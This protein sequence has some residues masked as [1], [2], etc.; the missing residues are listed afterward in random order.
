MVIRSKQYSI[1]KIAYLATKKEVIENDYVL[2]IS[3]YVDTFDEIIIPDLADVTKKI[4]DIERELKVVGK[5]LRESLVELGM[6]THIE[7]EC[8]KNKDD[9][10]L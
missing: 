2:N 10:R 6:Q 8:E 7:M 4:S 1:D 3:R 9:Y 5:K